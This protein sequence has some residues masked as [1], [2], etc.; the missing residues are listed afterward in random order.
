MVSISQAEAV[1]PDGSNNF[2]KICSAGGGVD[3]YVG[4]GGSADIQTQE[5]EFTVCELLKHTGSVSVFDMCSSHSVSH[6]GDV[7][8][9]VPASLLA[10]VELRGASVNI[11]S[12]VVLH[13]T[14]YKPAENPTTVMGKLL[15]FSMLHH[16]LHLIIKLKSP[17]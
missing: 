10:G 2:L 3:V 13:S 16:V 15:F 9:R 14:E 1:F 6:S 17:T 8:V 12:E 4:D 7:C 11:D 5:G